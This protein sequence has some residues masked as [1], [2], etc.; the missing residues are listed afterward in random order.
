MTEGGGVAASAPIPWLDAWTGFD[1]RRAGALVPW[2]FGERIRR[3]R[4]GDV[5]N[6]EVAPGHG[7]GHVT[8]VDGPTVV[9]DLL[10]LAAESQKA[11]QPWQQCRDELPHGAERTFA[12]GAGLAHATAPVAV[13]IDAVRIGPA[14]ATG[15]PGLGDGTCQ[16]QPEPRA[17]GPSPADSITGGLT[18]HRVDGRG[19]QLEIL[20][21][22]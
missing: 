3:G 18:A 1:S 22:R 14:E 5:R 17:V 6:R 19:R 10:M 15:R 9:T 2:V 7:S 20:N 11:L 12:E 13:G 8:G 16:L 4:R 21:L